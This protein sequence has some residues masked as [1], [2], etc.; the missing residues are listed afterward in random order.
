MVIAHHDSLEVGGAEAVVM[1][2]CRL[3][4]AAGHSVEVHFV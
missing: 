3:H 4:G 1:A 2:L